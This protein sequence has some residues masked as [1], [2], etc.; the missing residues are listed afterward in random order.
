MRLHFTPA[1][2][3]ALLAASRWTPTGDAI[4]PPALLLGLLD[5]P[6]CRAAIM[7]AERGVDAETVRRHWPNFSEN[8]A[9]TVAP[10]S[11]DVEVALASAAEHAADEL[12]TEHLLLALLNAP[13]ELA[14]WLTQQGCDP[15]NIAQEIDRL[16][17]GGELETE[18]AN[19]E[20]ESEPVRAAPPS[21]ALAPSPQ[22]LATLR[23][24]D[25]S[26]NR[27]R[28]G[29]RVIEDFVRF[30]LDDRHLT[31]LLKQL[32]HDLTASLSS[33]PSE[34]LLAS[35][36]TQHDVGS[37]VTTAAEGQR[38]DAIAVVAAS[39]K[40]VEESLRSLEEYGKIIDPSL[41][42]KF[43]SLRYRVYTLERAVHT[44]QDA[45]HRLASSR[46]YV[47]LDGRGSETAFA[48]MAQTLIDAH[49][50]VIQ[51]RDK[52]LNDRTLLALGRT[53]RALTGDTQT[54]FIMNDRPDLAVLCEADGVHV[55]QGELSVHDVRHIVGPSMLVGVS[56]H[57]I[58]QAR[59]AVLDGASYI[60]VGPVFPSMTKTFDRLAGLDFVRAV[61]AEIT[62]PAFAIGG[63][64]SSNLDD[65]LAAGL[66]RIAV[67]GAILNS[68]DPAATCR[69]FSRRL[70][71]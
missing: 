47:L 41:G 52:S 5:E 2:E 42:A 38:P 65:I 60:G 44:T 61:A 56:T 70:A 33:L 10:F 71:R 30:V 16:H 45:C 49:V 9:S 53:L 35:R 68:Q 1:A 64:T 29:L 27:C 36:E 4:E 26:A 22:P 3:R 57:S 19:L 23:I 50:D 24:L 40:R 18:E 51:L 43:E 13:H 34:Q 14:G 66:S 39:F 67:S 6:E 7:L 69:D 55:G 8:G 31:T 62:L 32:R 28:E 11:I 58:E 12:A 59:Q 20:I 25:A 63:V 17:G 48:Q 21:V 54:L 46:L 37:T 15:Q